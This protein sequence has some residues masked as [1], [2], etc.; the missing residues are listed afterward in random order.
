MKQ[1]LFVNK[2][3][4]Y[5]LGKLN[6][7]RDSTVSTQIEEKCARTLQLPLLVRRFAYSFCSAR[8]WAEFAVFSPS[9]SS[10]G[11]FQRPSTF[12]FYSSTY[13]TSR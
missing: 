3:E 4:R 10:E 8:L 5:N 2:Q 11:E 13:G 12:L 9:L 7:N 6:F 1:N